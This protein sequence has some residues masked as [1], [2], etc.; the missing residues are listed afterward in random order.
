MEARH[1]TDLLQ[2]YGIKPSAQRIAIMR[3]LQEHHTHPTADEVYASLCAEL[4]TLSKTTVYNTLHLFFEQG[5]I[6]ML[7]ID[8]RQ[9]CFD[10]TK[11]PHAH[12]RCK[13][14]GRLTDLNLRCTPAD[15]A[16]LP[17]GFELSETHLYYKGVCPECNNCAR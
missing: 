17:P 14:C 6:N 9:V 3:Y 2:A 7:T 13:V 11:E 5:A 10:A 1:I 16:D 15:M 8:D 12:F 4:P